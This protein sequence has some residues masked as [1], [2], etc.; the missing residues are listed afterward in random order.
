MFV[1]PELTGVIEEWVPLFPARVTVFPETGFPSESRRVTVTV[2]VVEPLAVIEV[3]L[4]E[5]VE[6]VADTAPGVKVTVASLP[7]AMALPPIVPEM[8]AEPVEVGEVRVA[9]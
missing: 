3:G 8:V 1:S 4:A 7:E 2:E 9:V 5:I 6:D